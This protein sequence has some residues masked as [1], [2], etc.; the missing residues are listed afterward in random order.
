MLAFC[1]IIFVIKFMTFEVPKHYI[2]ILESQN[3]MLTDISLSCYHLEKKSE[4]SI[5]L[6]LICPLIKTE[7]IRLLGNYLQLVYLDIYVL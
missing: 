5:Y 4:N 3:K 1:Q 7:K 2:N 6:A